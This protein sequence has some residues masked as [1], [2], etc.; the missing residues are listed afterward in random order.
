MLG[1]IDI[2]GH[3]VSHGATRHPLRSPAQELGQDNEDILTSLGYTKD[4]IE[5]LAHRGVI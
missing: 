2:V 1:D 3:P 5:D 4:Q